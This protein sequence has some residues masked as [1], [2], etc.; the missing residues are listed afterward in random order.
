MPVSIVPLFR[1]P[2]N[3]SVAMFCFYIG[4]ISIAIG[5]YVWLRKRPDIFP[6]YKENEILDPAAYAKL[7]G[8][9]LVSLG[10]ALFVLSFPINAQETDVV[11]L[12]ASL[13][14]VLFLLLTAL[15]LHLQA[16]KKRRK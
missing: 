6:G 8:Q 7:R 15:Y 4:L 11:I 5:L 3:A 13:I 9:S 10:F 1:T 16:G 14:F 12:A 2:S